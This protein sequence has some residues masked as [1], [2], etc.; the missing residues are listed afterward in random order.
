MATIY[1]PALSFFPG[2]PSA[3]PSSCGTMPTQVQ[4]NSLHRHFHGLRVVEWSKKWSHWWEWM[5]WV[6]LK[7]QDCDLDWLCLQWPFGFPSLA[8]R[9]LGDPEQRKAGPAWKN[10][11]ECILHGQDQLGLPL[12]HPSSPAP[13]KNKQKKERKTVR[14]TIKSAGDTG[15]NPQGS[16]TGNKVRAGKEAHEKCRF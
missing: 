15:I 3:H 1:S 6:P 4:L 13:L 9:K 5:S 7:S 8:I 12:P 14:S 10:T 11:L 16:G 2:N